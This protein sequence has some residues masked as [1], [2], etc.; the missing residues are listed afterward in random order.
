MNKE[1][2]CLPLERLKK[3]LSCL[4]KQLNIIHIKMIIL[5]EVCYIKNQLGDKYFKEKKFEEAL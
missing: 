5:V 1:T 2:F 3:L 4:K